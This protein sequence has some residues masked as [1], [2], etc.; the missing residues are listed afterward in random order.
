MGKIVRLLI[1]AVFFSVL[2]LAIPAFAMPDEYDAVSEM[3]N[4]GI[5]ICDKSADEVSQTPKDTES[6][7]DLEM[8]VSLEEVFSDYSDAT[9][10]IEIIDY[11]ETFDEDIDFDPNEDEGDNNI[12]DLSESSPEISSVAPEL[13]EL[14]QDAVEE[15]EIILT[16]IRN[17]DECL[18]IGMTG[19]AVREMQEYLV[20]KGY[21]SGDIVDGVF[22]PV[23]EAAIKKYQLY[24]GL[25]ITGVADHTILRSISSDNQDDFEDLILG[26][27]GTAVSELQR[28]LKALGYDPGIIDGVF[29]PMTEKAVTGFQ[30][31]NQLYADG[32]VGNETLFALFNKP[33]VTIPFSAEDN[34]ATED[35]VVLKTGMTGEKVLS[36]QRMLSQ[37]GYLDA[38]IDGDF[39]PVTEAAVKCFQLINGMNV[40]G[41]ADEEMMKLLAERQEPIF[42]DLMIGSEGTFVK[43]LQTALKNHGFDPGVIDGVFG[44]ITYNAV[45]DFQKA[46]MLVTDGI[47]GKVTLSAITSLPD[48]PSDHL[49]TTS[50][51]PE[52]TLPIV[53]TDK[54]GIRLGSVGDEVLQMQKALFKHG[55]LDSDLDGI[56]GPVTERALK[57]FEVYND[58]TISDTADSN[59][60]ACLYSN[61]AVPYSV[62]SEGSTGKAVQGIQRVLYNLGYLDV[63]PDGDFGPVTRNAVELFQSVNNS[64]DSY[65][66]GETDIDTLNKL[67][68]LN[69][70]YEK[71][72]SAITDSQRKLIHTAYNVPTTA[73]GLCS[74]WVSNVLDSFGIDGYDI[75]S[76]RDSIYSYAFQIGLT[77]ANYAY[78]TDFNAND[79]WAYVC[80]SDKKEEL[81]P[82]MVIATRNTYSYLG[83]QFGHVGFY[84][85]NNKVISSIG[86]IELA[87]LE[88]F[89]EK[90]NNKEYGSTMRWGFAPTFLSK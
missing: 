19:D 72:M 7:I 39:G 42:H 85:G 60:L 64:S 27:E 22:G 41:A 90:Y 18:R 29:G 45:I 75:V 30:L 10:L 79:Y 65:I 77:D 69:E 25:G 62:L 46:N 28:L 31:S 78:D 84:L 21:M 67:S 36:L 73:P 54:K 32:V 83:R 55:Y 58:L 52:K 37:K 43:C 50:L 47:V 81:K 53:V 71:E 89:D 3:E 17:T 23:T 59:I 9:E 40:T 56:F 38:P 24:N 34:S 1:C 70:G 12:S 5:L 68:D 80:T 87:E 26:C 49:S 57:M 16:D 6:F 44:T 8:Y 2:F 82:G 88:E 14:F 51:Q 63:S 33:G 74:G 11:D 86:Y 15:Q 13:T 4:C 61:S 35:T 66:S 76:S 20:N 48:N